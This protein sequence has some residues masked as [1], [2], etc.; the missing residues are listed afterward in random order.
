MW[1]KPSALSKCAPFL[2]F[3]HKPRLNI[4]S[5]NKIKTLGGKRAFW[6]IFV[7]SLSLVCRA[8]ERSIEAHNQ[9]TS[10]IGPSLTLI[11][12]SSPP[13]TTL[14]ARMDGLSEKYCTNVGHLLLL[15]LPLVFVQPLHLFKGD[16]LLLTH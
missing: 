7:F 8:G 16:I 11:L 4:S 3:N 12:R 1:W 5:Q 10:A 6:V 2:T 9:Q 13:C 14:D 15:L